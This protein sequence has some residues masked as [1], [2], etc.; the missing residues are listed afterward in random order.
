MIFHAMVK[1]AV[2]LS[3]QIAS[4]YLREKVYVAVKDAIQT[5]LPNHI[6]TLEE[7]FCSGQGYRLA[8]FLNCIWIDIFELT[9]KTF[10]GMDCQGKINRW[11]M[12]D[13]R[14]MINCQDHFRVDEVGVWA[15]SPVALCWMGSGQHCAWLFLSLCN[16]MRRCGRTWQYRGWK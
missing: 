11:D 14:D 2:K 7:C 1:D 16:K 9:S 8:F 4:E 13:R 5:F 10:S 3:F 6:W 12:I 15:F